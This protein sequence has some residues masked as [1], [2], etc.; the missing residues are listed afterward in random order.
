MCER[1]CC[2]KHCGIYT[3]V[4]H[5]IHTQLAKALAL[6]RTGTNFY[7]HHYWNGAAVATDAVR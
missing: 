7:T 3:M 6:S 5:I 1:V 2:N 4:F